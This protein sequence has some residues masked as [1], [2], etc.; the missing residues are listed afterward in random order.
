MLENTDSIKIEI[1]MLRQEIKQ[2]EQ[3]L[4]SLIQQLGEEMSKED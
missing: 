4:S 1:E 3:L 2:K